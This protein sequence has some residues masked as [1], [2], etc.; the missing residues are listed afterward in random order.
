MTRVTTGGTEHT[1]QTGLRPE[2]DRHVSAIVSSSS[3]SARSSSLS[4]IDEDIVSQPV[5]VAETE[6][7]PLA[8][9]PVKKTEGEAVAIT[10]PAAVGA[11]TARS[12]SFEGRR[13]SRVGG[14]FSRFSRKTKPA[15]KSQSQTTGIKP[16]PASEAKNRLTK[17]DPA[18]TGNA[19]TGATAVTADAP[20]TSDAVSDSSFRRHDT[21]LHSI[22]SV[23]SDED[24]HARRR[25]RSISSDSSSSEEEEFEEARDNFDESLAPPPTFGGQLKSQ[26]PARETR[27]QEEL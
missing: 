1:T 13:S 2:I 22:S 26:S 15:E 4:S 16:L 24:V 17:A 7:T 27:F 8:I 9:N 3:S 20:V 18:S 14:F 19:A 11:K 6:P 10:T 21:D 25:G 23:S 12:V 5:P